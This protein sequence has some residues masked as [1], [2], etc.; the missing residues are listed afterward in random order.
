MGEVQGGPA[1]RPMDYFPVIIENGEVLV[2]TEEALER[3]AFDS[4]Q[5][6]SA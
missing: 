1:P 6:T 3:K 2:N 4:S 5:T